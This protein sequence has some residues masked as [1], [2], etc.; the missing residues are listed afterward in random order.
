LGHTVFGGHLGLHARWKG[1]DKKDADVGGGGSWTKGQSVEQHRKRQSVEKK[2]KGARV[3]AVGWGGFGE[4][5]Y[6]QQWV[7]NEG[8]SLLNNN[9]IDGG[10]GRKNQTLAWVWF[11]SEFCGAFRGSES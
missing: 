5:G 3:R 6:T 10:G 7:Q 1:G 2:K 4:T 8:S 11:K 9:S